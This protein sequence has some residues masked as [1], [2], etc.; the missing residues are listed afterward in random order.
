MT[1]VATTEKF[2]L[3]VVLSY[4]LAKISLCFCGNFY[5]ELAYIFPIIGSTYNYIYMLMKKLIAWTIG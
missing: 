1:S 3:A 4:I 5:A 2:C